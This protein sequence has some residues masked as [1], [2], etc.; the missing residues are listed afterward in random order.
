MSADTKARYDRIKQQQIHNAQT[1]SKTPSL[2][3]ISDG[4]EPH[5]HLMRAKVAKE[6]GQLN[7]SSDSEGYLRK[8]LAE[9]ALLK[10]SLKVHHERATENDASSSDR[11]Q[12][13]DAHDVDETTPQK[14][15]PAKPLR[16]ITSPGN[17]KPPLFSIRKVSRDRIHERV[18]ERRD[19]TFG[20][21]EYHHVQSQVR[22]TH[23]RSPRKKFSKLP[24]SEG[25]I[26]AKQGQGEDT[27]HRSPSNR[28]SFALE[29]RLA[30]L[31]GSVK[32]KT[33]LK[34]Y[35][36]NRTIAASQG[37][38]IPLGEQPAEDDGDDED[39]ASDSQ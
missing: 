7:T 11:R 18:S 35:S 28:E 5:V 21:N 38:R 2:P 20:V 17:L 12:P 9:D 29:Q 25:D 8:T 3:K 31:P 33:P 6:L 10:H 4:K 30:K 13:G 34:T 22:P 39:A 14:T 15:S 24:T 32:I 1:P 37:G 19:F 26:S 27:D 23:R 16:D 36:R